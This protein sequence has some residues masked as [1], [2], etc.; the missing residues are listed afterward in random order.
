M[1]NA[2]T[3]VLG[4][5]TGLLSARRYLS[6]QGHQSSLQRLGEPYL[7]RPF[8]ACCRPRMLSSDSRALSRPPGISH[9]LE[10]RHDRIHRA[11]DDK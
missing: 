9:S 2:L 10:H 5:F 3:Q 8:M 4:S 11:A 7:R 6:R 1:A